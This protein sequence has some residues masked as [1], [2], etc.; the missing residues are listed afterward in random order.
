M[1]IT[2][3]KDLPAIHKLAEENIFVMDSVRA[4][5][6]AIRPLEILLVNLMP[7]KEVTETQI[8]RALS[9]TPLQLNMTLLHTASHK[10]TNTDEEYL[11]T[12]Y[13]TFDQV[14]DKFFDGMIITGAPV[15]LMPFESVDY[16]DEL[17][18]IMDWSEDHV[19]STLYLCWGAQAGLYHHF[20]IDKQVMDHKLFGVYEHEIY[21]MQPNL[22]RGFDEIF[23]MPHSRHTTNSL[24]EVKANRNLEILAGSEVTGA[25]IV[26]S[27][28]NKHIFVFGHAEYD[29]DT[30]K[31]EYDRDRSRGLDIAVPDNYYPDDD[32]SKV[33]IVRWR[34]V[35]TLLYTN[36][37]NYYVYQETPYIIEQIQKMKFERDKDRGAYI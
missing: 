22:L 33:P 12:F 24:A 18:E 8:L 19:F 25:A 9:N 28:D 7:T 15:E 29:R 6:Q 23:W 35:S 4:E 14:K 13:R 30:L 11:H 1:P 27:K 20:G 10:A 5:T 34:S 16:W 37:L 36:W 2:V 31:R 17:V 26:R 3:V 21:N 32:P